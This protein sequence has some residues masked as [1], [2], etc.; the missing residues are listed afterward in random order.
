MAKLDAT[1]VAVLNLL[2]K[3]VHRTKLVKLIYLIDEMYYKHFGVTVTGITYEW[4]N[5]GPNSVGDSIVNEADH[6]AGKN[7]IHITPVS[8][9]IYGGTSYLYKLEKRDATQYLKELTDLETYVIRDITMQY[10]DHSRTAITKASKET[11]PFK[12]AKQYDLLNLVK[13]TKYEQLVKELENN[14][15]LNKVIGEP[16]GAI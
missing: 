6:L 14:P 13:S 7:L 11:E 9:N 1:I 8:N 3:P 2:D 15:H 12:N 16:V 4:A 5:Y 10:K